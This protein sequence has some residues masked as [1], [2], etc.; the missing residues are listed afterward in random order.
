MNDSGSLMCVCVCWCCVCVYT[1]YSLHYEDQMYILDFFLVPMRKTAYKSYKVC[2]CLFIYFY[3]FELVHDCVKVAFETE[4]AFRASL[5]LMIVVDLIF[6]SACLGSS[7]P[8]CPMVF[9]ICILD[10]GHCFSFG[11]SPFGLIQSV[12]S[13]I[14]MCTQIDLFLRDFVCRFF[15][16]DTVWKDL[17]LFSHLI[18]P[19]VHIEIWVFS[20]GCTCHRP[21]LCVPFPCHP[22]SAF[23][24]LFLSPLSSV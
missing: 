15:S 2:M 8:G 17:N 1:W 14:D 22:S 18:C 6:H 7:F 20:W 16:C 4:G 24:C 3:L 10:T 13:C 23:P 19:L 12:L 21:Q 11:T 5:V 9:W